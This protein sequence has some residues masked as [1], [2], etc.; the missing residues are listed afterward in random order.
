VVYANEHAEE[1]YIVYANE[2]IIANE[3]A[4]EYYVVYANE[5]II[6]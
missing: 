4:D 3:Y 1:S 2:Y 6:N 5:C